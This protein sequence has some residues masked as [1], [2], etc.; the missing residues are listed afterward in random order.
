MEFLLQAAAEVEH[1]FVLEYLYAFYSLDQAAPAPASDWAARLRKNAVEEMGHLITVQNVLLCIGSQPYLERAGTLQASVEP[2]PL[3]LVPFSR[4]FVVRFLIAESPSPD[5]V[6][7]GIDPE[8]SKS[9]NRVGALYAMLTW[10][11]FFSDEEAQ[12]GGMPNDGTFPA[13]RHLGPADF[14]TSDILAHRINGPG[15]WLAFQLLVLPKAPAAN[16]SPDLIAAAVRDALGKVSEQ[17]EGI[18]LGSTEID[19]NSH[20]GRLSATFNEISQLPTGSVLPVLPVPSNPHV[21]DQP[22]DTTRIKA[23]DSVFLARA[24]NLRYAVLLQLIAIAVFTSDTLVVT[25]GGI[26]QNVMSKVAGSATG[27]GNEMSTGIRALSTKLV[28]M[29]R[30]DD[31]PATAEAAGPPFALPDPPLPDTERARWKNLLALLTQYD[32]L[33]ADATA[34]GI[35]ADVLNLMRAAAAKAPD[36]RQLADAVLAALP[37]E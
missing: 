11:F 4:D 6:P 33:I 8:L 25:V 10:M 19:P 28:T 1:Q 26:A 29:P 2:F 31:N 24:L 30:T 9:I 22:D 17:G 21:S 3:N 7:A 16:E 35:A 34:A 23:R 13:G 15:P 12:A 27:F 20:F 37:A 5:K 18:A 36:H 14:A 32:V